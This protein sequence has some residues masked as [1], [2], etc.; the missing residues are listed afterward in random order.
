MQ[1]S[2]GPW[3]CLTTLGWFW[4]SSMS[5]V[6]AHVG[7]L[8]P[9]TGINLRLSPTLTTSHLPPPTSCHQQQSLRKLT[10]DVSPPNFLCLNKLKVCYV[11]SP[12]AQLKLII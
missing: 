6:L 5:A 12:P 2:A 4:Y 3:R 10:T 8:L 1:L 9:C 11:S 7:A